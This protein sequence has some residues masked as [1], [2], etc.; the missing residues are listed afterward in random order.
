MQNKT[1]KDVPVVLLF[2]FLTKQKMKI[3][4]EILSLFL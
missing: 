4:G 2:R 1:D 3:K